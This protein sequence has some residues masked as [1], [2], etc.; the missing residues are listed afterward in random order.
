[1]Q[2]RLQDVGDA[3]ACNS[4]LERCRDGVEMD[5]E[6]GSVCGE[7]G[8]EWGYPNPLELIKFHTNARSRARILVL[9]LVQSF[10]VL[11]QSF[12][13]EGHTYSMPLH[14]ENM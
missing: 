11:P 1:M 12:Y 9:T 3:S 4:F 8:G 5:Q 10:L 2:W 13:L 7:H 6:T 14:A